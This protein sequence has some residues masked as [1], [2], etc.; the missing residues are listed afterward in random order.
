MLKT[1]LEQLAYII[2]KAR[3]FD[4]ETAPVDS[5]SGSNPSDDNDVSILEATGDN[6]TSQEL[7]AAL[8][9][10]NDEQRIEILALMWLGRGDFDRSGWR[11]AL[12][13]ARDVHNENETAYLTGTPL[14]ADYLE[15]AL[16]L[17]GY[18]LE[19]FEKN[20]L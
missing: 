12:A 18:S 7:V 3:E 5:D 13:Q 16:D 20:R 1:P 14:L 15:N 8:D 6:P 9:G 19:D 10:L 17:L 11:D 4:E 2:E